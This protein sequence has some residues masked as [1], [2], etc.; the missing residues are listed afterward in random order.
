MHQ[1]DEL[2]RDCLRW[3]TTEGHEEEEE[4]YRGRPRPTM[5]YII[6]IE[7]CL[8]KAG[9]EDGT[10]SFDCGGTRTTC[11]VLTK[12]LGWCTETSVL[13]ED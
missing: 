5:G 2:P 3:Q 11:T 8:E 9:I 1:Q 6:E 13:S 4:I 10:S 7:R 12:R